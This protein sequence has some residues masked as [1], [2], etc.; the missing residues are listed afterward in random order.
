MINFERH[1]KVILVFYLYFQIESKAEINLYKESMIISG[2]IFAIS[3]RLFWMF[4]LMLSHFVVM[5]QVP[6]SLQNNPTSDTLRPSIVPRSDTLPPIRPVNRLDTFELNISE[7]ALDEEVTYSAKDSMRLD[8]IEEKVYLYG[9]AEVNYTTIKITAGFIIFDMKNDLVICANTQDSLGRKAQM[10]VFTE[11]N[12]Q[13]I[14]ADSIKYNFITKKGIVKNISTSQAGGYVRSSVAKIIG[15]Q[16]TIANSSDEVYSQNAIYTTCDHPHPHYGLRSSKQKVIT[17]KVVV[18]GPSNIEVMGIPTPLWLPFGFFPLTEN[19]STGLIFPKDYEYSPNWGYG[20]RNVGWYF[21]MGDNWDLQVL[22]DIYTRGSWGLRGVSRYKKR[23]HSSGNLE[24][25]FSRRISGDPEGDNT[26][27][28]NAVRLRWSHNQDAKAHPNRTFRGSVNIETNNF[29]RQN[30]NDAQSVLNSELTSSVY[31]TQRFPGKPVTLSVSMGH[32]QNVNT[33]AIRLNLP[34]VDVQVRKIFPFER[35]VKTGGE[36]WYERIGFSYTGKVQNTI[37]GR[38]TLLFE[39][40]SLDFS[41]GATHSIPINANF[42][43]FK[44]INVAP[45]V[46]YSEKWYLNTLRREFDNTITVNIDTIFDTEGNPIDLN[47]DTTYGQVNDIT[48]NGFRSLREATA[49]VSLN[50]QLFGMLNLRQGPIKA[51]RHILKPSLSFNFTPDYTNGLLDYWEEVQFDT[52][53][54]DEFQEYNIFQGGLFGQASRGGTRSMSYNITNIF[55]AKVVNRRDTINPVQKIKLFNNL[56]LSGNYNFAADSL[57]MSVINGSGNTTI[58]KRINVSFG[59]TLDPLAANTS[60]NARIDTYEWAANR[61]PFRWTSFRLS[62]NTRLDSKFFDELFGKK[63][64]NPENGKP[65]QNNRQASNNRNSPLGFLQ[66]LNINYSFARSRKYFS[67][68]DSAFVSQHTIR[69]SGGTV[70]LS[71]KWKLTIGGIGYD[72][73]QQTFTYPDFQFYR[74]LHCWEMGCSW[75]P[76]RGTYSFYIRVKQPSQLDFLNIPYRKNNYDP[77]LGI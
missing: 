13:P 30:F 40:D 64:P 17:D 2:Q 68:V 21:G 23:Y 70:N 66:N 54:P 52:R 11:G 56:G 14:T 49:G 3:F 63:T 55:E 65:N 58:L 61:R 41:Y 1:L 46:R 34:T 32:S 16:D 42:K 20:I 10:P 31:Y 44:Y 18:I 7:D 51:I 77:L 26:T 5:A 8:A 60:T 22:G 4:I 67:G 12:N 48:E 47:I 25:G 72:F 74:D 43:L 37:T 69:L 6:D 75:Q 59:F 33:H 76:Q 71:S 35:K 15:K 24:L 39:P 27:P 62:A 73:V 36:R 53:Y 9:E 38:D 19:Q 50:T 28:Q 29:Q 57:K 45:F